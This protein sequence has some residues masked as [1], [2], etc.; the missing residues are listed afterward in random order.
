M[1]DY[2]HQTRKQS[3]DAAQHNQGIGDNEYAHGV[4]QR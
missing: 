1:G 3:R 2:P 4:W